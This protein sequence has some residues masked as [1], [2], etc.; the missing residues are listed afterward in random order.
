[1]AFV[2]LP[3]MIK[4]HVAGFSTAFAGLAAGLTLG[5]GVAVQP[6]GRRLDQI[7]GSPG[8]KVGVGAVAVGMLIASLA[9]LSQNLALVPLAVTIL[10]AGY[11][12]T[13]VAGLL[14]SNR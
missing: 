3:L 4:A 11:G 1:M 7:S 14:R 10:G 5:V 6:T 8:A 13:L 2:V 12:L 9:T